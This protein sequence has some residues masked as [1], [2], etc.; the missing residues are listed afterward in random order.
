ML[1]SLTHKV[2]CHCWLIQQLNIKI[3][4]VS[5]VQASG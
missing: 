4:L 5:I 1:A 3:A 2:V